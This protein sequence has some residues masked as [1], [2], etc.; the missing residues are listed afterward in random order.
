MFFFSLFFLVDFNQIAVK[1]VEPVTTWL[2]LELAAH[3][4]QGGPDP[5]AKQVHLHI[6]SLNRPESSNEFIGDN[7]F[8]IGLGYTN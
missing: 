6:L 3:V 5:H 7:Q 4:H 2:V 8:G 1:M